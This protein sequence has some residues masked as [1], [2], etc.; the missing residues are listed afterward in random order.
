[1]RGQPA[2]P[3]NSRLDYVILAL[4]DAAKRFPCSTLGANATALLGH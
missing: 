3:V 4:A 2:Q 1:L